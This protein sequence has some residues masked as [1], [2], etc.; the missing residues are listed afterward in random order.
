MDLFSPSLLDKLLASDGHNASRGGSLRWTAEQIKESVARDIETLLN[1]CASLDPA[2]CPDQP[3]AG[4]SLLSFGLTDFTAMNVASDNDRRRIA[5]SIRRAVN[6]HEP[7]LTQVAVQV[8]E[9]AAVGEGLCFAIRAQLI[10]NPLAEPVAFDA[11]LHP[12]S[13]RYAVTRSDP[14]RQAAARNAAST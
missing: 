13:N 5:E 8:R 4:H 6:D 1:T 7:R 10:L 11:M 3:L 12:G 2:D 9:K 14:R